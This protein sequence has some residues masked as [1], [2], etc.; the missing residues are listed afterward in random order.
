MFMD[1]SERNEVNREIIEKIL[2]HN[3]ID[4]MFE[5]GYIPFKYNIRYSYDKDVD[6][7]FDLLCEH[8]ELGLT[9]LKINIRITHRFFLGKI[10]SFMDKKD[11]CFAKVE[12]IDY[13]RINNYDGI[14]DIYFDNDKW[15]FDSVKFIMSTT[16][17][18]D[19]KN[20]QINELFKINRYDII[21]YLNEIKRCFA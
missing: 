16:E 14:K 21:V 10:L 12:Y 9:P 3:I 20:E 8:F 2:S 13:I 6:Y 19:I 15:F 11:F 17:S 18:N 5:K 4:D 7:F 1:S